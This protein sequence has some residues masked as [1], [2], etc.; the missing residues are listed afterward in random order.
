MNKAAAARKIQKIFRKRRAASGPGFTVTQ[1]KVIST[2]S[3]LQIVVNFGKIFYEKVTGFTEVA[4]YV[5]LRSK[6]RVR[7]VNGQWIGEGADQCKY[8]TAKTNNLTVV[9]TKDGVQVSGA[10]NFEEAYVKCAKNEW[11]SKSIIRMKPKYKIINCSFKINKKINLES[12]AEATRALIPHDMLDDL[13]TVGVTAPALSVKF[14]KPKV[15]YQIFKNGTILFSGIT[16]IDDI[17]VPVELFK[18]FFTNYGFGLFGA[19]IFSG[20]ATTAKNRNHPLAGTWNKLPAQVPRG[21]YIRPGPNGLPRLYPYEFYRKL[22]EGPN[23]L[24]GT[25]NLGPLAPKV[26]KAFENAGKPIPASTLKVFRNAGH[27]LNAV[28]NKKTYAGVSNR[29]ANSWNAT[30]EGYYVRPGPGQQPYWFAVPKGKAA[31]RK[32]VISTYTA[33]GRNIP[34][35]VRA[36]FN[37]PANV[38]TAGVKPEHKFEV[39][40]NGILRING[41]QATRLTKPELLAVARNAGIA[42]VSNKTKPAEII[43]RIKSRKAPSLISSA[44]NI[45]VGS[46]KYKF[47]KDGRVQKLKSGAQPTT[48]EWATMSRD[49]KDKII[50]AVIK[51]NN[52]PEFN[53]FSSADQ[54]GVIYQMTRPK[55]KTPSPTRSLSSASSS[56]NSLFANIETTTQYELKQKL[57][58]YYRNGNNVALKAALNAVKAGPR[59]KVRKA[60][61]SKATKN[62]VA[63]TLA[64]RRRNSA[65][66]DFESKFKNPSWLPANKANA[67]KAH[68]MKIALTPNKETGKYP[69][70]AQIANGMKPWINHHIPQTSRAA[71]NYENLNTGKVV[72]VPAWNPPKNFKF[73][74]PKIKRT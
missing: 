8:V 30:K 41:R 55:T 64:T 25:V 51:T 16:K 17:G 18:Q 33:A 61:L 73:N 12:F 70:R 20:T 59:G 32:T 72:R 54:F 56:M 15:T 69:K 10:G 52:R 27:P 66:A 68:M 11:V 22:Q 65:V 62:F 60:N 39:G 37:I 31:G 13:P 5:N 7:Y 47:M 42:E 1:P 74:V 9:L 50:G 48:R 58:N 44:Y 40:A 63:K 24:N 46:T 2:V 71:Y 49:A 6:P 38:K 14:K 4:G 19:E 57:K 45:T 28:T 53:K 35:A 29:R 36:L 43:A 23:I 67:F 34:A 21:Y 26:R 3:S